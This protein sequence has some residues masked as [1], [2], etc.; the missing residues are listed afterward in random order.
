MCL[1][2]HVHNEASKGYARLGSVHIGKH[3]CT[4]QF[5]YIPKMNMWICL[6][7]NGSLYVGIY[8]CTFGMYV[9]VY[10]CVCMYV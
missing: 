8:V 1:H 10:V 9:C 2:F 4:C 6:H 3:L 5:A 7:I